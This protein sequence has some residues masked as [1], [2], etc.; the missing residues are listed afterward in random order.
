MERRIQGSGLDLEEI[1]RDPLNMPGDCVAMSRP[2]QQSAKNEEVERALQQ[3]NTG[4]GDSIHF[5]GILRL[6]V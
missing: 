6:V 1:F 5:V 2:G 4:K 3:L